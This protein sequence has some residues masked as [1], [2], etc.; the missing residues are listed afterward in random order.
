L[1][2][3]NLTEEKVN[4][5][6]L[7]TDN[8][9]RTVFHVAAENWKVEVFHGIWNLAKENLTEEGVNKILLPTDNEGRT[10]FMWQQIHIKKR[11]LW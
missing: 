9:G 5:M 8:E 6:L 1:A 10:V 2:K 11:Y 7:A 4:K 3:K